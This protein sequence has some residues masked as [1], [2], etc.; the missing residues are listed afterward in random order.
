MMEMS[1]MESVM[2]LVLFEVEITG[3][4]IQEIGLWGKNM[5][6]LVRNRENMST[7]SFNW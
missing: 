5:E 3:F 4:H 2:D 7:Y 6:R 1:S